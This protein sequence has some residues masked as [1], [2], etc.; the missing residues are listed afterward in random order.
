LALGYSEITIIAVAV[1]TLID[2]VATISASKGNDRNKNVQYLGLVDIIVF[3]AVIALF[4]AV[5]Y[6][7]SLLDEATMITYAE[8]ISFVIS[9]ELPGYWILSKYD[10]QVVNL[11]TGIRTALL[12]LRITTSF[13][14]SFAE[15]KEVVN[16]SQEHLGALDVGK[17]VN[18]FVKLCEQTRSSNPAICDLV[19]HEVTLNIDSVSNRTKHPIP[20]LIDVLSLAG[21]SFLIAQGLKFLG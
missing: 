14:T 13:A 16:K 19:L 20:K 8:V 7:A 11:F 18:Q 15:F 9:V 6:P 12:D 17:F 5:S 10:D 21:L 2:A 4:M 1:H 3:A